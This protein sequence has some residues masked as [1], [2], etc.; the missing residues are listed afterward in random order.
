MVRKNK[1]NEQ[2]AQSDEVVNKK[3]VRAKAVRLETADKTAADTTD[4]TAE[5]EAQPEAKKVI[6][7]ATQP[8]VP[9]AATLKTPN[10]VLQPIF[11]II[12]E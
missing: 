7:I 6:H 3:T 8:T 5:S 10:K 9:T 11:N 2:Q 4:N 12:K 1:K